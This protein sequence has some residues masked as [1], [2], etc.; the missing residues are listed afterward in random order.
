MSDEPWTN[1]TI[2]IGRSTQV[3]PIT[4][5]YLVELPLKLDSKEAD[6]RIKQI[7][8]KGRQSS[9]GL[10]E[11]VPRYTV[12]NCKVYD[13]MYNHGALT[14]GHCWAIFPYPKK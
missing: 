13:N 4:A 12:M 14:P 9:L 10:I 8:Q 11:K 5:T 2:T 3:L 6:G 7:Y 1:T